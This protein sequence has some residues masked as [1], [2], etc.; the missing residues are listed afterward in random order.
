[1]KCRR[2]DLTVLPLANGILRAGLLKYLIAASVPAILLCASTPAEAFQIFGLKLFEG[3]QDQASE[4]V[5]GTPQP[6]E[7]EVVVSGGDSDVEDRIRSA[8]SL[9]S[10]REKPASGAAGLIA[11]ARGDYRRILD[12]SYALGR[13]GPT[14]SIT[15]NGK[16]AAGLLPDEEFG[17]TARV[18]ISV[19]PGPQFVFSNAQVQNRA[20]APTNRR[21]RVDDPNRDDFQPG[22]PARS[23]VILGTAR[24]AV[25]EWRQQG[26]P[27]ATI[28]EQR[29]VAAHDTDTVDAALV[30]DPGQYAVFGP[31]S[32]SGTE[33]MDPDFVAWMTGIKPG[34]EYDPDELQAARD[35]L[36][37]LGVFRA[38]RIEEAETVGADGSL[39]LHL[40]VQERARRR[41]SVGATYSTIDGLGLE[42]SWLHRNLFGRAE[43]IK[44]EGK[45][46]GIG[47]TIDPKKFTYRAGAT[48]TKPGVFTPD[49]DFVAS[50][51]GDREVL[52][53]YT[54]T[55]V[56]GQLGFT[57]QF[58]KQLSGRL[59]AVGTYNKFEDDVFGT[60]D[61]VTAGLL[62]GLT[63][64]SRDNA[65]D[66]TEGIYADLTLEPYYEFNYG[67]A[68]AKAVGEVRAYYSVDD[69]SRFVV[70]GRAKIG[71][72]F[73][74]PIAETPPDKLFF[75]GGG[76]S[77]RGYAYR[78]IGV[79]TPAGV[80][81]GR[82][83]IEGSAELRVRVTPTIGVVAFADAGYVGEDS[84]PDFS[85]DLRIGVGG[86]LRY[87]TGF[88]PIRL[89]VAT[90]LDRRSGDPSVAIYV[91]IGQAF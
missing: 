57:Y 77:V 80:A 66:A 79:D 34:E 32:V 81:G 5:I 75:A 31:V 8:S 6:Y 51:Y 37:R 65:A 15:I 86:G 70:A 91:G 26:Y 18:V 30:V 50:L 53:R 54:R 16:E 47:E 83:L 73:D 3:K 39:P 76:G 62:G 28:S 4:E 74:P 60:R 29:I 45:V 35:R 49:T 84:I 42:A 7:V 25:E 11:T 43:S 33:R 78:N 23:G 61:F 48:F 14:I 72:I 40:Y 36:A 13:Y 17:G 82:S 27:K 21:D 9:W 38:S 90:P 20:P 1:M 59:F 58:D 88:G 41:F 22:K 19:D 85:E 71:A 68:A 12:T 63:Y 69:A 46:A 87:L 52:E 89:D 64:D 55:G 10:N 44:F 56:T 24:T 67:N 2:F